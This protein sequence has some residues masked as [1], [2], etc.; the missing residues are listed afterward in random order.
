[1]HAHLVMMEVVVTVGGEGYRALAVW[2]EGLC[3]VTLRCHV[4]VPGL[5]RVKTKVATL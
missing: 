5:R 3:E 2:V 4:R 1:M